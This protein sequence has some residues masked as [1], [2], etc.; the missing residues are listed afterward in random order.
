[1][2]IFNKSWYWHHLAL[3]LC[4][5]VTLTT[6]VLHGLKDKINEQANKKYTANSKSS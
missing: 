6:K 1:M 5:L 4:H 3:P 2:N